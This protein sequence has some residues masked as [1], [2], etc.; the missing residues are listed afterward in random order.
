MIPSPDASARLQLTIAALVAVL[1]LL[2]LGGG[3]LWV[4]LERTRIELAA[5]QRVVPVPPASMAPPIPEPTTPTAGPEQTT[6]TTGLAGPPSP[7]STPPVVPSA[8]SSDPAAIDTSKGVAPLVAA[9]RAEVDRPDGDATALVKRLA[10]LKTP[11]A[12][13]ALV[14]LF[15]YHRFADPI[16]ARAFMPFL[17]ASNDPRLAALARKRYRHYLAEDATS[18]VTMDVALPFLGRHG[19]ADGLVLIKAA[20]TK[21]EYGPQHSAAAFKALAHVKDPYALDLAVTALKKQY[22]PVRGEGAVE[23]LTALLKRFGRK[24]HDRFEPLT[25]SGTNRKRQVAVVKALAGVSNALELDAY[26]IGFTPN[27]AEGAA[28]LALVEATSDRKDLRD[29][30]V[31]TLREGTVRLIDS[32]QHGRTALYAL[33][34]QARFHTPEVRGAL[35]ARVAKATKPSL[36]AALKQTLREVSQ[37]LRSKSKR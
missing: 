9:I 12:T 27:E 11:E 31:K 25:T 13:L 1:G 15:T 18:W 30:Q 37:G 5:F 35:Q 17:M 7:T 26:L 6:E 33:E 21:N 24:A 14:D 29:D 22:L 2:L 10:A 36:R 4:E 23:V 32:P 16:Y 19:G 8:D 20:L 34:Y 3:G 28:F